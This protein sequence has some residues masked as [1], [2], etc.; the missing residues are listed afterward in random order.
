ML[1]VVW[2]WVGHVVWCHVGGSVFR[3][4]PLFGM[5]LTAELVGDD[6]EEY[7]AGFEYINYKEAFK[8]GS[9]PAKEIDMSNDPLYMYDQPL[10]GTVHDPPYG[11]PYGSPC[12]SPCDSHYDHFKVRALFGHFRS[13]GTR[14]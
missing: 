13:L 2:G 11:S 12:G 4:N 3:H 7:V 14:V 10:E 8:P 5:T 6:S 1:L 9:V